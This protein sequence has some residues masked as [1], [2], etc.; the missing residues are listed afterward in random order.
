M[1]NKTNTGAHMTKE[2][3]WTT[4]AGEA[5]VSIT[6]VTTKTINADG[7]KVDV[8]CCEINTR[9]TVNGH[10]IGEMIDKISSNHP[11]L[12]VV[13]DARGICGKLIIREKQYNEIMTAYDEIKSTPEWKAKI[14]KEENARIESA[15]DE[16]AKK[17]IEKAMS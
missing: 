6:L 8:K 9:V 3:T 4:K 11:A 16:M 10:H 1:I 7:D 17:A 12:S 14:E 2:I 5:K 15:K 13:T